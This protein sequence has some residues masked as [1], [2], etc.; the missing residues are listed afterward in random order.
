MTS[1]KSVWMAAVCVAVMFCCTSD[2]WADGACCLPDGTCVEVPL[3][4]DCQ[5]MGGAFSGQESSCAVIDCIGACCLPDGSCEQRTE[6]DCIVNAFGTFRGNGV[7]CYNGQCDTFTGACSMPDGNC[8]QLEFLDCEAAGGFWRGYNTDCGALSHMG[9]CCFPDGTCTPNQTQSQCNSA[10]GNF[11]GFGSTCPA[12]DCFQEK[13]MVVHSEEPPVPNVPLTLPRFDTLGGQRELQEVTV[14]VDCAV[15]AVNI[16]CNTNKSSEATLL[17]FFLLLEANVQAANPPEVLTCI[18]LD[19]DEPETDQ[20]FCG[21]NPLFVLAPGDC[22]DFGSSD[23]G[24][25]LGFDDSITLTF[26]SAADD[27]SGFIVNGGNTT[28][29]TLASGDGDF[30]PVGI[31]FEFI[32]DTRASYVVT[33]CYEFAP[34]GACCLSDGTCVDDNDNGLTQEEC[35]VDMGGIWQGAGSRCDDAQVMCGG[36]CCLP[37]GNCIDDTTEAECENAPNNGIW[38]GQFTECSD[39]NIECGGACCLPDGTCA[40]ST[41][42]DECENQFGG[43]WQGAFTECNDPGITCTGACCIPATGECIDDTTRDQCVGMS[44]EWQGPLTECSDPEVD[45]DGA[46]CLPDGTCMDDTTLDE[47]ENQ[48]GGIWQGANTMCS[49]ADII[50]TGACCLPDGTCVDNTSLDECENQLGGMWQGQFS[51]CSDPGVMCGGACC[52]PNGQCI[53]NTSM[54]ECESQGGD[55]QGPMTECADVRCPGACCLP[56]GSCVDDQTIDECA[57]LGGDWQGLNTMCSDPDVVCTGACCLPGGGCQ[58]DTTLNECSSAGGD[59]Q[60]AGTECADIT[61]PGDDGGCAEKG[62]L[63]IFSK[64]EIRWDANGNLLQDTFLQ[65]TNDFPDNVSIQLY[66]VNGDPPLAATPDEREHPGWNWVDNEIEL[67][68]DQ[69]TYWSA[70][71]GLGGN[72]PQ[73]PTLSP[74]TVLDPGFPPGRPDPEVPGERMLRGFVVAWAVEQSSNIEIRWNH[75][76]GNGTLVHYRDGWSWEYRTCGIPVVANVAHGAQTGVSPGELHLDN[77]EYRSA[78]AELLMN[79]QAVN[80]SAFS[81]SGPVLVNS[82]TDVTLHPIDAD[83]RQE[84]DGPVTTKAHY[85]VWNQ[86]ES[87]LS[88]AFRCITCWDQ[89]LLSSYGTPNHFFLNTLQTDHGKARIDGRASA[90]CNLDLHGPGGPGTPPDGVPDVVSQDAAMLGLTARLMSI[91]AGANHAADGTNMFGMGGQDAVI[92]YDPSGIP[93]E[94][95]E[96]MPETPEEFEQFFRMLSGEVPGVYPNQ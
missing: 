18:D 43:V 11:Q 78:S 15:D 61:C 41:T 80:S 6:R 22:C 58:D 68:A 79:F 37:D 45:C 87:K 20:L 86:N 48:L 84:T 94:L 3:A 63:V 26:T 96:K 62:S 47:C 46:C 19:T 95:F 49:D 13:Y 27:L 70:L 35:E 12:G 21:P 55:W 82:T 75:L 71:T 64:V 67:T 50:C 81:G 14:T 16:L 76:A 85:S 73:D 38:Q 57:A 24:S 1:I 34:V 74:F 59:W 28:F 60:G 2:A 52:L 90:L 39:P 93:P 65:L 33:V 83:L 30:D 25:A 31:G 77:A 29:Q 54:Q 56:D 8:S 53:E 5:A 4:T 88:G 32:N 51:M 9:A 7:D 69:P 23:T 17:D 72:G 42:L 66:F 44:G 89:T 92:K 40:D 10:G 91:D 36:A